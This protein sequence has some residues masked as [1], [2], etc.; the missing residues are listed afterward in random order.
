A[1]MV[2]L[3][4][5]VLSALV[6]IIVVG[7]QASDAGSVESDPL[8]LMVVSGMYLVVFGLIIIYGLAGLIY[9]A[10]V[11]NIVWSSTQIDGRHVLR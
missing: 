6:A 3:G 2:V 10:A 8:I 7:I 5:V 9:R 1:V 11:H 4:A